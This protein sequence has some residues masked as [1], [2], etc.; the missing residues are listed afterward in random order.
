MMTLYLLV[1]PN[2]CGKR[3]STSDPHPRAGHP[4]PKKF[5]AWQ[6]LVTEKKR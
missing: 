4:C 2:G 5:G 1:C 3:V 6:P